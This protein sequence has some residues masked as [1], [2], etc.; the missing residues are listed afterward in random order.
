MI[1]LGIR[2]REIRIPRDLSTRDLSRATRG[3]SM[4]RDIPV[5]SAAI[6]V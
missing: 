2:D 4:N 6:R 3:Q 1:L 5:M